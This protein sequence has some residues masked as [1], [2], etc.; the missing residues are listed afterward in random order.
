MLLSLEE[1]LAASPIGKAIIETARKDCTIGPSLYCPVHGV[2]V[3]MRLVDD[4]PFHV[5]SNP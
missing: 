3:M 1:V 5:P 2:C 4:V